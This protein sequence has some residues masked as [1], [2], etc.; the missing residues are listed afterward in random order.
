MATSLAGAVGQK[1]P[2]LTLKN[3]DG[4]LVDL[5]SFWSSGPAVVYFYPKDDTP[6]CTAE[7]CTFRDQF[8]DFTDAGAQVVGI[9]A[10]SPERHKK[11][12]EKHR[13]PFVLLSDPDGAAR[14]G[15]GVKTSF[16][17]IPGRVTF[18]IDSDGVIQ[19]RFSSQ[20]RAKAHIAKSIATLR[21]LSK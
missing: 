5:A 4:A 20:F 21:S 19:E 2:K 15:F 1:A 10:D 12:K 14:K 6:G 11:F 7:A 17:L 13:L 18:V 3:H 8:E 16:G 9:S